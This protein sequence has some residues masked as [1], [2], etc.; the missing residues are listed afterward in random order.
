VSRREVACV[1]VSSTLQCSARQQEGNHLPAV[2]LASISTLESAGIQDSGSSTRSWMG[3]LIGGTIRTCPPATDTRAKRGGRSTHPWPTM[4]SC[5]IL[6]EQS[7]VRTA[8][9]DPRTGH[10][11]RVTYLLMLNILSILVI[12]NQCRIS[13]I[14]AWKRISF[15]PAMF[16][17]RLK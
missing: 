8:A 13:G 3:I 12:P 6:V 16:S 1:G 4:A 14:R 11:P 2:I 9:T 7:H 15:T 5:F 10:A 17:V